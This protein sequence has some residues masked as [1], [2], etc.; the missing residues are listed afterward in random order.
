MNQKIESPKWWRYLAKLML[1]VTIAVVAFCLF[2]SWAIK[3]EPLGKYD[4][5]YAIGFGIYFL[6]FLYSSLGL[7]LLAVIGTVVG[8]FLNY[9]LKLYVIMILISLV[10]ILYLDVFR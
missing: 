1:I 6:V 3:A 4:L 8:F 7:T 9:P 5:G 10:P 2:T